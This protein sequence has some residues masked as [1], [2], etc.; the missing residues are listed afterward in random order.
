MIANVVTASRIVL[1][2]PL[3]WFLTAPSRDAHWGALV[4]LALAGL[5]DVVDGRIARALKQVSALGAMLDLVADR[6]LTLVLAVGLIVGGA[7]PGAWALAPLVLLAR[8]LAVASFGEATKGGVRFPVTW[9]ERVKIAFQFIG[10]GLLVAPE[11][12]ERQHAFGQLALALAAAFAAGT[13]VDYTRRAVA[14][15]R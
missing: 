2:A 11:V 6:L 1:A 8:D 9:W 10:F 14:A 4:V 15:L 12:V 13:L 3:Y 5:T 7:L